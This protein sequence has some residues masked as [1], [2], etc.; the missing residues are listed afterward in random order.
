MHYQRCFNLSIFHDYYRDNVCSDFTIEPTRA[1]QKLLR[2]HRLILK[3]MVNG[4][5]VLMPV[6]AEQQPVL[7]LAESF[8]FTFLLKLKNPAF[9]SFTQLDADYAAIASL[10]SFSNQ[11]HNTPGIADLSSA[12]VQRSALHPTNPAP[13]DLT[14]RLTKITALN[15]AERKT[16]FGVVEIHNNGSLPTSPPPVSE[17]RITFA[18][19][20][21]IW[22]YYLVAAKTS[23]S[24]P[25]SIHDK[26]AEITFVPTELDPSDRVAIAIQHRFP[27][28]QPVLF[29]SET[30]I[31]CQETGRQNIQL[32]KNGHTK[33]WIPHLPNPPNHHGAQVINLLEDV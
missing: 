9:F 3:P 18:A 26:A 27:D 2:G 21:Q 20:A 24:F 29:Q 32:L 14:R 10:Y 4:L 23:Q 33:P 8:T 30:Q 1:C 22:K 25:F 19:K 17:F 31:L 7:P 12:L 28:S 5:W 16:V 13:T 11:T 6:D 15:T